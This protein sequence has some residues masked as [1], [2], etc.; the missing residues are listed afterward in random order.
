[1][2]PGPRGREAGLRAERYRYRTQA[3]VGILVMRF[4]GGKGSLMAPDGSVSLDV[5]PFEAVGHP[6]FRAARLE[7]VS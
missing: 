1:M 3:G 2:P 6:L 5:W 4:V 7:S